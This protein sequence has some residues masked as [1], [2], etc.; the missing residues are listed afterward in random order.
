MWILAIGN[1]S[2]ITPQQA[3]RDLPDHQ[4]KDKESTPITFVVS[5]R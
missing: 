4:I 2:P 5:K 3:Q 1:N